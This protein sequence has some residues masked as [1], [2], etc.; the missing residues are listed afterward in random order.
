MSLPSFGQTCKA[1][2]FRPLIDLVTF[3]TLSSGPQSSSICVRYGWSGLN[4]WVTVP[5]T[6]FCFGG[7]GQLGL[8]VLDVEVADPLLLPRRPGL[9]KGPAPGHRAS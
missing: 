8:D 2:R 3:V 5:R 4:V 1:R 9:G 7:E 6:S